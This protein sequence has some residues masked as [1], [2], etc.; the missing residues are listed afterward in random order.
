[1]EEINNDIVQ[2]Q[3][4]ILV[5]IIKVMQEQHNQLSREVLILKERIIAMEERESSGGDVWF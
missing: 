5:T 3:L 4:N 1:M 2:Q